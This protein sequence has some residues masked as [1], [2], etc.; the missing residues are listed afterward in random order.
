MLLLHTAVL[1]EGRKAIK[2]HICNRVLRT[3]E[4]FDPADSF[5]HQ[6][7][8]A[9]KISIDGS[10]FMILFLTCQAVG[11]LLEESECFQQK[12]NAWLFSLRIVS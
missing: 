8:I 6:H 4:V 11:N 5:H 2:G 7:G 3:A 1:H 10:E 9:V 12:W